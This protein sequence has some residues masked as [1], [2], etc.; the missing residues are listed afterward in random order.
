MSTPNTYRK[1][2]KLKSRKLISTLFTCGQVVKAY[3]FRLHYLIHE[4][5]VPAKLQLGVSVSKRHFKNAVDR[6]RVK[7]LMREAFRLQNNELKATAAKLNSNLSIMIIYG[8]GDLPDQLFTVKKI[9]VLLSKL[10]TQLHLD[11]EINKH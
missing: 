6:N 7:R 2:E 4:E 10:V 3:P 1:K 11:L 8:S 5:E 9:N